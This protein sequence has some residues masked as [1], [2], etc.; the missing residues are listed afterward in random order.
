MLV[1]F[2]WQ[3]VSTWNSVLHKAI[4]QKLEKKYT[5]TKTVKLETLPFYIKKY[6]QNV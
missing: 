3:L 1:L 6:M 4:K 5:E 2:I